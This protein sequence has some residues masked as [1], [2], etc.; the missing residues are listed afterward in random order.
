MSSL[1]PQEAA[2]LLG[3]TVRT[4]HRWELDG[5][6]KSTRTAGGHRR[7]D[8][9]D[10]ISNKSDTQLTVGYARVSS[11]DQ[12]EDLTRQV[13]VLESYC[14]KHG[15]GFEVIQ[16]LGS[17]MNYKKKG[18]IRLIKL[19]TSYQ[20][21]RLVLTHKDRLLRFG[22]D[23]IFTLCEQFGTEVIIINRSDDSTFE[24]DLASDVLEIITVFSA[25][26]Y[27]SRSHKNKKIVEELKE[28]AKQL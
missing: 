19:I 11:H 26:L 25:R 17:G 27:G 6:I 24:E 22:S 15:W 8:I 23:L 20:V 28:V 16:D 18:L 12:K 2:T 3:V 10:L 4:L 1:T 9:A 21:E 7:Y 13:I 14:A 5:K